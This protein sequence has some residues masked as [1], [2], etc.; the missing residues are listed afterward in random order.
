[1]SEARNPGPIQPPRGPQEQQLLPEHQRGQA[2][3]LR[4]LLLASGE[5]TYC[6][7]QLHREEAEFAG[8]RYDR[9]PRRGPWPMETPLLEQEQGIAALPAPGLGV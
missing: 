9:G 3:R 8:D 5:R 6:E 7:I 4:S 2:E 1:M